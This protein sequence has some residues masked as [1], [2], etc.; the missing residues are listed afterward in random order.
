MVV[1]S[2]LCS[3]AVRLGYVYA[4]V[5][6]RWI[7]LGRLGKDVIQRGRVGEGR[8]FDLQE[9][10]LVLC[11]DPAEFVDEHVNGSLVADLD[12]DPGPSNGLEGRL[13]SSSGSEG[14]SLW[15]RSQP[16]S[17]SSRV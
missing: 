1:P 10:L 2:G 3:E 9:S 5:L 17:C 15:E 16:A 14:P 6:R 4:G 11:G 13:R 12:E 7:V 8:V